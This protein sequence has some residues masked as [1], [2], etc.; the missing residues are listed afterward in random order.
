MSD[1]VSTIAA[2]FHAALIRDLH[3][4]QVVRTKYNME[5][6]KREPTGETYDRR[7]LDDETEVVAFQQSWSD[8]SIGFGGIAGQAFT[9]AYTVCVFGPS[10]EVAVYFGARLAYVI[11]V[12]NDEFMADLAARRMKEVHGAHTRYSRKPRLSQGEDA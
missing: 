11:D 8:T 6:K 4:V 7:P 12:P 3:N 2:S 5:T 1:P 10:R 9:S